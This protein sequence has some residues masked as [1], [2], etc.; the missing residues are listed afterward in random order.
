MTMIQNGIKEILEK[1]ELIPVVTFNHVSEVDQI[2]EKL[3]ERHLTCIE[4]TLRTEAAL[5]AIKVLKDK[6]SS[7]LSIG[8][9]T[10][11]HPEQINALVDLDV[12]FIVSP[13]TSVQLIQSLQKTTIPYIT[14]VITPSEIMQGI[15]LNCKVFKFFPA[16]IFGGL[17]TLKTYSQV[18]PEITFCP[19]GGITSA[20]YKDF[21]SLKNVIAVGGSW[22]MD[23]DM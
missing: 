4:V 13:G 20:T 12:D 8:V 3:I 14:G 21:L 23:E 2:A 5:A 16:T 22:M 15:E 10:V 6:Y 19:T 17:G 9:G 1:N 7:Q 18:F 11:I